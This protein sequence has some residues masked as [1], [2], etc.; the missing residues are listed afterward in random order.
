[1]N[2]RHILFISP[3]KSHGMKPLSDEV[4]RLESFSIAGS[5]SQS[6]AT[7]WRAE[8]LVEVASAADAH[9]HAVP[10]LRHDT[11]FPF[12]HCLAPSWVE[13]VGGRVVL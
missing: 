3:L 2:K 7:K 5:V 8:R 10:R 1:M 6:A 9:S 11:R 4:I 12:A 13:G